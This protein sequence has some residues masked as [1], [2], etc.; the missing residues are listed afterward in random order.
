[1]TN[2]DL[3]IQTVLQAKC[4]AACWGDNALKQENSGQDIICCVKKLQVLTKWIS[5]LED[6]LC[7]FYSSAN[8]ATAFICLTEDEAL[9]LVGKTK[10]LIGQ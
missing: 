8:P 1:M 3:I 4:T 7:Q 5:I 9:E 6:F 2:Q 10:I